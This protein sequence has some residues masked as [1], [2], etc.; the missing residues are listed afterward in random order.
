MTDGPFVDPLE[1][2][3]AAAGPRVVRLQARLQELL[4]ERGW[5][6]WAK[7]ERVDPG[8]PALPAA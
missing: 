5:S 8:H 6:G 4:I 1:N 2:V 7:I 3:A